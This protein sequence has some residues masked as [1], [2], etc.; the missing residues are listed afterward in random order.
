MQIY[1]T[2]HRTQG[3]FLRRLSLLKPQGTTFSVTLCGVRVRT[4]WAAKGQRNDVQ[5]GH[6][7]VKYQNK[8]CTQK[9]NLLVPSKRLFV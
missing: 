8:L 9:Q 3:Y 2:K 5:D 4:L 6:K 1:Q 7:G